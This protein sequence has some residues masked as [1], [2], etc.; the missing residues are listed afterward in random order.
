MQ[1][2][3]PEDCETEYG[4]QHLPYKKPTP[5]SQQKKDQPGDTPSNN[6]MEDRANQGSN[7]KCENEIRSR[8]HPLS[9]RWQTVTIHM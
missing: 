2:S 6:K 8:H 1:T 3:N 5:R 7:H 4:P 9:I